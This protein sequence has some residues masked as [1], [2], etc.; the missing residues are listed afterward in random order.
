M[1]TLCVVF[2][3]T[4][5]NY[6]VESSDLKNNTSRIVDLK[7]ERFHILEDAARD[8]DFD[9]KVDL[10]VQIINTKTK[11]SFTRKVRHVCFWKGQ[12][13][14]TWDPKVSA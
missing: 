8:F 4:P 9:A 5:E 6:K 12:C 1:T 3:S 7:D 14:I 10:N 11:E 2:K 13:V